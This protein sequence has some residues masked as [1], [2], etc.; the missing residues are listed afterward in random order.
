MF[1]YY[2]VYFVIKIIELLQFLM[3]ARAIFSWFPQ[4]QGSKIAELLYLATEPFILP[5][6]ALFDRI[7]SLRGFMLDLPFL[8][9]FIAMRVVERL[10]YSLIL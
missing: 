1:Q 2:F 6:R 4:A 5:F 8:F 3:L 7:Q 9:A 10:L